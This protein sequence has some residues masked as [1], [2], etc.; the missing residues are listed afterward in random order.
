[1]IEE[2][3]QLLLRKYFSFAYLQGIDLHGKFQ[4]SK[5]SGQRAF[6]HFQRISENHSFRG[7]AAFL[8]GWGT[9]DPIFCFARRLLAQQRDAV[10]WTF[11]R[12]SRAGAVGDCNVPN[13][14]SR[15][16]SPAITST[17]NQLQFCPLLL[18]SYS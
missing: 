6:P 17:W 16:C 2:D 12:G 5:T 8:R 14:G 1:M 15:C 7:M 3:F 9:T 4:R 11:Q 10:A 13:P 18:T